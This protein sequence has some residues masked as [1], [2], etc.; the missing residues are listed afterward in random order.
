MVSKN[1]AAAVIG[2]IVCDEEGPMPTLNIS[3]TDRNITECFLAILG[4]LIAHA[5]LVK[6]LTRLRKAKKRT[7]QVACV[8]FTGC[9]LLF[10]PPL[11]A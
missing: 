6:I 7:K 4:L 5:C 10:C 8:L 1:R 2:P 3:K 11:R 9:L